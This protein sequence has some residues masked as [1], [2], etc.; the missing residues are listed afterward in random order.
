MCR[1]ISRWGPSTDAAAIGARKGTM[2][3]QFWLG[4][5]STTALL[6]IAATGNGALQARADMHSE[7][8]A[9]AAASG[10]VDIT[11]GR[12]AMVGGWRVGVSAVTN[13]GSVK[14]AALVVAGYPA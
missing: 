7:Q 6:A 3:R 4:A 5:A 14:K 12:T 1:T 10:S 13:G 8:G 2:R 9:D 11:A